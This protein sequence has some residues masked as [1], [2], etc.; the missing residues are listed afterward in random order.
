[1]ESIPKIQYLKKPHIK[2]D[3]LPYL[4]KDNKSKDVYVNLFKINITKPLK[5]YQYP[6]S[7]V[8]EIGEGDY[9]IRNKIFRKCCRELK[10]VYGECFFYGDSLYGMKEVNEIKDIK[11]QIFFGGRIEYVIQ[12]Q[13]YKQERTIQQQ[14]LEKDPLTKQFIELLIRDILHANPNLEFFKGLFVSKKEIAIKSE[15]FQ[16]NFY[17]G[18]TT[19]FMETE[20][21][22]YLNVT[23]KNKILSQETILE[24]LENKNYKNKN[25]Q[26]RLR[27]KLIG[28]SFKVKYS[29]RN[30]RID[31]ISF[32]RNPKNT[33][34]LN[35]EKENLNLIKYYKEKHNIEIKNL[36]QPLIIVYSKE[37]QE[38]QKELYFIPELCYFAGLDDDATKDRAFMKQLADETKLKPEDRISKTNKFLDLLKETKKKEGY[39]KSSKE[40]SEL[41]G[42][43]VKPLDKMHKAYYMEETL[44][45][46]AEGK[47]NLKKDKIFKVIKKNDFP[48]QKWAFFYKK[49]NYYDA[50]EFYGAL[51]TAAESYGITV[52]EPEWIGMK[53]NATGQDW[54]NEADKIFKKNSKSKYLFVV[55]LLDKNDS[56]Y[57]LLKKHSLCYNGYISQVVKVNSIYK[58]NKG[59]Y[60]GNKD[61]KKKVDL[62]VCSKI[63]L[64]INSKLSGI[65]YEANFTQDVMNKKIMVIGVDSSHIKGQRTGVAMVA[66][67]NKNFTE[68]YNKE[69]IIEEKNR[70]N[71]QF[72]ISSFIKEALVEYKNQLKELPQ[73]IIIYRQGVSL[74]QKDY[75]TNEVKN[76]QKE[77]DS[78]KIKFYYILVNTKT[79]Y[80]FFEKN[81]KQYSNP[82]EGLLILDGVTNRNFFEFYIQPQFVPQGASATPSCFHVAYG[83]LEFAEM[84]PKFTF[85]LC[86]LY[87]NWQG[88]VR[89]PHVLKAAE[90]LSKITAKYTLGELNENLKIG[91]SYL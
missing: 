79:T 45:L 52:E 70:E 72:C 24:F 44:L 85:D 51:I 28:T 65:S 48:Y 21:G 89:V 35:L 23:L 62:S 43:E 78:S 40:K 66:T 74:Q 25:N 12:L 58:K 11:C 20:G 33:S 54:K 4:K 77:L 53:N 83:D 64:Q 56:I 84:I 16:I 67:I 80:K 50:D 2:G 19:S 49:E 60:K 13:K 15:K 30:Y 37:P 39:D 31:D 7:T 90:K 75:L 88:T 3:S 55:F 26:E 63:I 86:H 73:G 18:Y 8:P 71:L 46:G 42:I 47:I 59:G 32:D 91:Q 57:P 5:L 82:G 1:M 29:K 34:F 17:P 68:F 22:N 61:N 81:G 87:S 76:I 27:N 14:D 69:T 36:D 41:Y 9:K 38:K 10:K 6:F